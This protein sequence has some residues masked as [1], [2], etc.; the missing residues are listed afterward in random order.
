MRRM[1][2]IHKEF[3][4]SLSLSLGYI[5]YLYRSFLP[6]LSIG[7]VREDIVDNNDINSIKKYRERQR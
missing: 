5:L 3:F 6:P 1:I 4:L 2:M 7:I